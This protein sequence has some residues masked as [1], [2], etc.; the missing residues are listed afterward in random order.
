MLVQQVAFGESRIQLYST[1]AAREGKRSDSLEVDGV[2]CAV[3]AICRVSGVAHA[4]TRSQEARVD[5]RQQ[6][7]EGERVG[8][9]A[10]AAAK[11]SRKTEQHRESHS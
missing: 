4:V 10:A 6:R 9:P 8:L 2:G 5:C 11:R 1:Q 3:G 7:K